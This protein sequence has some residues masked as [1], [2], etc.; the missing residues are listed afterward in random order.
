MNIKS[1]TGFG[2]AV[3]TF[4]NIDVVISIKSVNSKYFDINFRMPRIL[5]AYEL[6]YKKT[7]QERLIRG[8]AD[9]KIDIDMNKSDK[10]PELNIELLRKYKNIIETIRSET[11]IQAEATLQDY[12]RLP[13]IIDLKVD[14]TIEGTVDKVVEESL[15]IA[16]DELDQMRIREGQNLVKDILN[17]VEKILTII[18]SIEA[19]KEDVFNIWVSNFRAKLSNLQVENISEDRIIQESIMYGERADITEEIVRVYSHVD[20]FKAIINDEL[21]VGKKLDFL[22]IELN[23]EFNTLASKTSKIDMINLVVEAKSELDKIREQVANL[24]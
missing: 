4:E 8:K 24:L 21:E 20:Q 15:I 22:L 5:S 9:I 17:R 13:D 14:T 23:R 7:I 19:R 6:K 18:K 16:I 2:K 1:M 10:S 12:L 3:V 11:N